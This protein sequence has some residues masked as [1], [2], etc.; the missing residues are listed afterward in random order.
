MAEV[1]LSGTTGLALNQRA[2]LDLKGPMAEVTTLLHGQP[3][4]QGR[5]FLGPA[6]PLR[7]GPSHPTRRGFLALLTPDQGKVLATP[8]HPL[9]QETRSWGLWGFGAGLKES[10]AGLGALEGN[11]RP[12]PSPLCGSGSGGLRS[13]LLARR[14]PGRAG[15]P[16]GQ[17]PG[18]S[19]PFLS[20]RP[21]AGWPVLLQASGW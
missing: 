6:L 4:L 10:R 20:S 15:Q 9:P 17:R 1:G 18:P 21:P 8:L 2:C 7:P 16:G 13:F 11:G 14:A 3:H 19:C 12:Q 5:P